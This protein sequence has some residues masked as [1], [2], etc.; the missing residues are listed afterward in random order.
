MSGIEQD[1]QDDR[2]VR[3][4]PLW[5]ASPVIPTTHY[6]PF[7]QHTLAFTYPT[8]AYTLHFNPKPWIGGF[9]WAGSLSRLVIHDPLGH[10]QAPDD[11]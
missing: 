6:F 10:T 11:L 9:H 1:E 4:Q 2:D 7:L 3:S 8:L 5:V